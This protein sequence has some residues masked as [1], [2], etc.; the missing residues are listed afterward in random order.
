MYTCKIVFG[1]S[2]QICK[3][4]CLLIWI[5]T[6]LPSDVLENDDKKGDV[7]LV[8]APSTGTSRLSFFRRN[9]TAQPKSVDKTTEDEGNYPFVFK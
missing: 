6:T 3:Y 7:P 2:R 4:V 9:K 5:Y 1:Q 8:A